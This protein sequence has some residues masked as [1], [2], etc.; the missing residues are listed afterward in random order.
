MWFDPLRDL[1]L[2]RMVCRT[3]I[4]LDVTGPNDLKSVQDVI[5]FL[6]KKGRFTLWM[7]RPLP[8]RFEEEN[9]REPL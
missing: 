3:N 1:K 2:I 9:C 5:G 6:H 8:C 7:R 4:L